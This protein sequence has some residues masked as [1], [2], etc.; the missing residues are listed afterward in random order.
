M[1]RIFAKQLSKDAFATI[2]KNIKK[3]AQKQSTLGRE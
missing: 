2:Q 1:D 3:A